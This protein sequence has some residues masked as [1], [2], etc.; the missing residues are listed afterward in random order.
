ME[1]APAMTGDTGK[2]GDPKE[3]AL[4]LAEQAN[5]VTSDLLEAVRA[6]V[7]EKAEMGK[8]ESEMPE[9][10]T[11]AS[12]SLF[13][14]ASLNVLRKEL[15][16]ELTQAM[17]ETIAS[18]KDHAEELEMIADVYGRKVVT[19]SNKNLVDTLT[20]D[21]F[22]EAKTTIA[23]AYK[24]MTAF[25]KYARG[26]QA[27]VKRAEMEALHSDSS[28]SSDVSDSLFDMANIDDNTMDEEDPFAEETSYKGESESESEE[29]GENY[30]E[31]DADDN[32][33]VSTDD[34]GLA[35][36]LDQMG[37][38]DV[39][40]TKKEAAINT[41]Q[42][43]AALR[44]KLAA[45]ALGKLDNGELQDMSKAKFSDML[46]QGNKLSD[47]QTD[48]DVKPSDDLGL[49]E[50]LPEVQKAM[51]D[52][53]TAPVKVRKEAEAIHKL[54]SEGKL[55]VSEL[56]GLV[57]EGLDSA[58]VAYYK[59]YYGQVDGG[60]EFASELVKEHVKAHLENDLNSY[61]VKLARAYELAYDMVDRGLCHN[62]R[63]AVSDQVEEIMKF[64]DESFES[65]K[66]VVAKH[67]PLLRKEAG[68][69]PQV[70]II[71]SGEINSSVETDDYSLLSAAFSKTSKRMF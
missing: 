45:D 49:V 17:K 14:T 19:A 12:N 5:N 36:K 33:A 9:L 24:L 31:F 47:G 63:S 41:K 46:E 35:Q 64:N 22:T 3:V 27:I 54:V 71:G 18:L 70:G 8:E 43:R 48:L 1:A 4:S 66:R 42:G 59:K 68:R 2:T 60:S 23:D 52:V 57:A 55:N 67:T 26:T 44:A 20:T 34:V 40:V 56:D 15:N 58:A 11:T 39:A 32:D 28:D 16:G 29:E 6:L 25:V 65:L 50:T 51:M 10:G 30:E 62:D 38:K 7:G 21:A 53:A 13:S 61:K 37:V 69:M